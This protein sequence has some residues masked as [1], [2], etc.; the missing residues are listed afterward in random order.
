MR[1]SIESGRGLKPRLFLLCAILCFSSIITFAQTKTEAPRK[2]DEFGD[3]LLTDIKARADAF[4]IELQNNPTAKG[5]I[6]V[7]RSRRDPI[8]LSS[9]Y[10]NR[11][12]DYIVNTRGLPAERVVALDAGEADCLRQEFWIVPP[13]TTITPREDAYQRH[14]VDTDS[15]Q[16]FDEFNWGGEEDINPSIWPAQLEAFASALRKQARA[17]G[18]VIAYATY[19]VER[20]SYEENGKVKR[21]VYVYHDPPGSAHKVLR[22]ARAILIKD[23]HLRPGRIRLVNGGYRKWGTIALWIV[24]RGEHAPIATP[25]SFPPIRRQRKR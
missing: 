25:N 19:H 21:S 17:D 5:F 24:P 12:R 14:F 3:A 1:E 11:I 18:Y 15:A 6:V 16:E 9:R 8:G 2:F 10:A 22:H 13:G 4:A 7:Y 23:F 20:S